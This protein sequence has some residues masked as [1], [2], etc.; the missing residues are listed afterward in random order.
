M[1]FFMSIYTTTDRDNVKSAIIDLATG[2]RVT[3]TDI[4]GKTREFHPSSLPALRALLVEIIADLE[5]ASEIQGGRRL[6]V[7]VKS[8]TW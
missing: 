5:A 1:G 2:K 3:Q 7:T 6:S 8:D 4:G